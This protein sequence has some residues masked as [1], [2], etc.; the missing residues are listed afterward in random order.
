MASTFHR[1][2]HQSIHI[3]LQGVFLYKLCEFLD[4]GDAMDCFERCRKLYYEYT[5][6]YRLKNEI[7][8][9]SVYTRPAFR[10]ATKNPLLRRPKII[11]GTM[12]GANFIRIAGQLV[13]DDSNANSNANVDAT[14]QKILQHVAI[15]ID[16]FLLT[17]I[18]S[19]CC[20]KR[21]MTHW[22]N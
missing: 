12:A 22:K 14:K 11:R 13:L 21:T 8:L 5:W 2:F 3:H 6:H 20:H 18:I 10:A 4:D 15:D 17:N 19:N 16:M 7:I 9:K 1:T